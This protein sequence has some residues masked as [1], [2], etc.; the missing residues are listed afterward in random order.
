AALLSRTLSARR[1]FAV[2]QHARA[3]VLFSQPWKADPRHWAIQVTSSH[4]DAKNRSHGR[5]TRSTGTKAKPLVASS[6]NS[7]P[8]LITKLKAYAT[9]LEKKLAAISHEFAE[10]R[11][12][13]TA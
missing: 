9:D 10:A 3:S 11:E 6:G 4:K 1:I 8:S 7:E 2:A 13:Q 12:Q 5:N